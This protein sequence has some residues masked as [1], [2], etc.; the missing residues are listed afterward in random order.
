[1]SHTLH[2]AGPATHIRIV[3]AAL[4]AATAVV[5]IGISARTQVSASHALEAQ[6]PLL[7]LKAEPVQFSRYG[8]VIR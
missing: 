6:A 5:A 7:I 4:V 3:A 2:N 1:M 8:A